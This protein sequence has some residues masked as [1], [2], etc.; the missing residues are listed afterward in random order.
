MPGVD[1]H[2]SITLRKY[3]LE[4]S[5]GFSTSG[6]PYEGTG[7]VSVG[8]EWAPDASTLNTGFYMRIRGG[9]SGSGFAGTE[10]ILQIPDL[11]FGGLPVDE[12]YSIDATDMV[13]ATCK[14]EFGDLK[15]YSIGGGALWI[16]IGSIDWYVDGVVRWSAPSSVSW[17]QSDY[18]APAGI[19]LFGIMPKWTAN[20][21]VVPI[22]ALDDG[23]IPTGSTTPGSAGA[24]TDVAGIGSWTD[25]GEGYPVTWSLMTPPEADC[26]CSAPSLPD[27]E[28]TNTSAI[29]VN[30]HAHVTL[31]TTFVGRFSDCPCPPGQTRITPLIVDVYLT[32]LEYVNTSSWIQTVPNLPCSVKRVDPANYAAMIYR[33][34]FPA[35]QK[36]AFATCS[37][38]FAE[39]DPEISS[40]TSTQE[41]H[42]RQSAILGRVDGS[43]HAMEDTFGYDI[44]SPADKVG[45]RYYAIQTSV[46]TIQLGTCAE[47]A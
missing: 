6:S 28:C 12:S 14:L 11:L 46:N 25:D 29:E 41:V 10:A 36:S 13:G 33:G 3:E 9:T 24:S 16:T 21:G 7:N 38:Y 5:P 8:T 40:V 17:V 44:L 30:A 23:G 22:P 45:A 43:T 20:A 4:F 35:T 2:Q 47:P 18:F 27:I 32:S 19:P 15:F 39:G 34:G 26:S 37:V 1:L 42:P 31:A